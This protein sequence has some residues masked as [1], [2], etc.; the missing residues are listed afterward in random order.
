[1]NDPFS[2][3][4]SSVA[5][6]PETLRQDPVIG[7]GQYHHRPGTAGIRTQVTID[8]IA[9]RD[10]K[11]VG[12]QT[13]KQRVHIDHFEL[14]RICPHAIEPVIKD[15]GTIRSFRERIAPK[16]TAATRRLDGPARGHG[17][18]R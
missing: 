13:S 12:A 14:V 16:S 3:R 4:K 7:F 9:I 18:D 17:H 1:V 15:G 2:A 11:T 10:R 8:V 6:L 5:S